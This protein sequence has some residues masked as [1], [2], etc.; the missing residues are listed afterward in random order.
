MVSSFSQDDGDMDARF[1]TDRQV[2]NRVVEEHLGAMYSAPCSTFLSRAITVWIQG[3]EVFF[4][5]PATPM[6][7]SVAVEFLRS[8]SR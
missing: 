3:F 8:G 7:K 1:S 4:R 5:V 6:Q 2:E